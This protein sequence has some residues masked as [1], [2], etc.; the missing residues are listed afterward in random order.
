MTTVDRFYN[1]MSEK[2]LNAAQITRILGIST[3]SFTDWKKG[4]GNPSLEIIVKFADYFH[5]SLDYLVRGED[6][7]YATSDD[8]LDISNSRELSCIKKFRKLSPE[9]Q[10]RLLSYADGM[11]AAMPTE[12]NAEE[13]LLG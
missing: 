10:D 8:S 13:R 12:E 11:I 7:K 5:V 2:N 6:F 3:S 4:K 1:L 9:L